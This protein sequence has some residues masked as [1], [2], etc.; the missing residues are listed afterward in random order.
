[1]TIP[2]AVRRECGQVCGS[3]KGDVDQSWARI[4]APIAPPPKRKSGAAGATPL[5][6]L[7]CIRELPDGLQPALQAA[8]PLIEEPQGGTND[9]A[10]AAVAAGGDLAVDEG[11]ELRRERDV[12]GFTDS[13]D[14]AR[15]D[16]AGVSFWHLN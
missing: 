9:F 4:S 2:T 10:C 13:H 6:S 16:A 5:G 3:P 8:L 7:S 1:M 12:T 14:K 15:S 11:F